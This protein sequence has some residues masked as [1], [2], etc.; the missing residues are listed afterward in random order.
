[1]PNNIM[2][3]FKKKENIPSIPIA[4]SLPSLP[5][6]P[7]IDPEQ[8]KKE[9]PELPSFPTSS[10]NE[11][12]NQELVKSAVSDASPPEEKEFYMKTPKSIHVEKRPKE[13]S[14]IPL[15]P[16]AETQI[17]E[18]PKPIASIEPPIKKTITEKA[19]QTKSQIDKQS[20]PIFVRIDKFQAAQKNFND[21]KSKVVE[22]E[23]LLKKIKEIKTREEDELKGWTKNTEKLKSR[24]AEIDSDI[25]SQL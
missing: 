23:S 4:P 10:K 5:S 21:I 8:S 9:L 20:D 11:N 17:P 14:T 19:P 3:L 25:F 2:G 7:S 18:L 22:M 1:M 16:S 13:E 6:L 24:L 12:L 15:S